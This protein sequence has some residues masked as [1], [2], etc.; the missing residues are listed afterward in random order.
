VVYGRCGVVVNGRCGEI[1]GVGRF[2]IG[3]NLGELSRWS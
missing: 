2:I 1:M 3:L